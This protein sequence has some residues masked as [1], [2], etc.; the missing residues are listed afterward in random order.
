V[1]RHGAGAASIAVF[2]WIDPASPVH[3][4]TALMW[5]AVV[6]AGLF[7]MAVMAKSFAGSAI[8]GGLG[9]Y[10]VYHYFQHGSF[11]IF[12]FMNWIVGLLIHNAP[13]EMV[14]AYTI[15]FI[16]GSAITNGLTVFW[17]SSS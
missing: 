2:R 11:D 10:A 5:G 16:F 12:H 4:N 6:G 8:S 14:A 7:V 9:A 15:V 13:H 3:G 1:F 17:D